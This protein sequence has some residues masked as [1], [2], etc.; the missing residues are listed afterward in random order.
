MTQKGYNG[1]YVKVEMRP[2]SCVNT[3]THMFWF[4]V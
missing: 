1:M 2:C 3:S 4:V